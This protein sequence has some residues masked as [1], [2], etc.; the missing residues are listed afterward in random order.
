MSNIERSAVAAVILGFRIIILFGASVAFSAS[1]VS[2]WAQN[3]KTAAE[4]QLIADLQNNG[5]SDL[6]KSK[7]KTIRPEFLK[8]LITRTPPFSAVLTNGMMISNA[9]IKGKLVLNDVSIPFGLTFRGC[10]FEDGVEFDGD[11]FSQ[12]LS[13]E[14]SSDRSTQISGGASF[15]GI[16][17]GT[18]MSLR[19]VKFSGPIDLTDAEIEGRLTVESVSFDHASE[20]DFK[21]RKAGDIDFRKSHFAG[22]LNLSDADVSSLQIDGTPDPMS[23]YIDGLRIARGLALTHI[24]FKELGASVVDAR[25]VVFDGVIPGHDIDLSSARFRIFTIEGFDEWKSTPKT[26][27]D[28]NVAGLTFDE[29]EI[30]KK[31][32]KDQDPAKAGDSML[33]VIDSPR[34]QYSSQIYLQ[35]E[36]FLRS[37]GKPDEADKVF[38]H[39]RR[40][41]RDQLSWWRWPPNLVLDVLV[42]YGKKPWRA[43]IFAII[44][45]VTGTFLFREKLMVHDD[46]KCTDEWYVPFWFSLDLLSPV[47]LGI[48]KKWRADKPGLRHYSQVHRILGWILIPLIAAAITGIIK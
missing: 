8:A 13:F 10:T 39:M 26:S 3:A 46:D 19:D 1:G 6:Y 31:K 18:V 15:I 29:L 25:S 23:L 4:E 38:I 27:G 44:L 37:H 47:D 22:G 35:L 30:D 48:S 42:G 9:T 28:F 2:L 21:L 24:T 17:V 11:R 43:G 41:E 20:A 34:C 40:R 33:D 45:I 5:D 12:Y 7:D 14:G 36:K 32:E 16:K